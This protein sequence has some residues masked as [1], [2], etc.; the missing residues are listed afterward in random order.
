MNRLVLA[1]ILIVILLLG[2]YYWT[3]NQSN[4]P[5]SSETIKIGAVLGLTGSAAADSLSIKRGLDLAVEDLAKEGVAVEINYQDDKTDAKQTVSALQYLFASYH[6]HAIVGPAWS[7][8]ED[9]GS[10]T[11]IANKTVAYAPANTTEFVSTKSPYHF[12]GAT[13]NA[14]VEQPL[15]DW[16]KRNN[17]KRVAIIVSNDAW[18]ESN[19]IPFRKAAQNAGAT[20]V[21]DETITA[22]TG[23]EA[24][25]M[26]SHLTKAK[27]ANADVILWTGY[28]ADAT[29][30]A[31]RRSELQID[32]SIVAA[33]NV[34]DALLSRNVVSSDQ[35]QNAY[36]RTNPDSREFAQKFQAKYSMA[37]TNYADRAYDG[38]MILVD[39]IQNAP[40]K[41]GDSISQYLRMETR[42][43]GFG[44]TYE[45]NDSGD[46]EGGEWVIEPIVQ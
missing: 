32:A 36:F 29:A 38:L 27:S 40:A 44:G 26:S 1:G 20:I 28:E 8:L 5:T 7:F 18:G 34:F 39:A 37:P 17:K 35:L 42:Y 31:K 14:L 33:S 24:T 6:P 9:A 2:G 41:D 15:T 4:R 16:L 11:I 13:R 25:T 22:F 23:T 19:A 21:V 45:F 12:H 46:I 10:Q 43:R 3:Q 30:L